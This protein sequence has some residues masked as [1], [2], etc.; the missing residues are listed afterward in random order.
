[1]SYNTKQKLRITTLHDYA[2]MYLEQPS[3]LEEQPYDAFYDK[4]FIC[5]DTV[6]TRRDLIDLPASFYVDEVTDEQMETI[7]DETEA[8]THVRLRLRDNK[9][10]DFENDR[11][12]EIWWEEVEAAVVNQNIPYYE[13]RFYR[14]NPRD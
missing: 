3:M 7:V 5:G 8:G 13:D 14:E 12:R 2:A 6:L 1:M 10:I 11:Q 4:K 9:H